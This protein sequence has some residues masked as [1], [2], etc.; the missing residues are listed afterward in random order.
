ME[1]LD[2][3]KGKGGNALDPEGSREGAVLEFMK[4]LG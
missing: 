1:T 4:M 3:N 2:A